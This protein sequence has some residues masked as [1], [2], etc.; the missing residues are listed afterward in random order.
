MSDVIGRWTV[1]STLKRKSYVVEK[2]GKDIKTGKMVRLKFMEIS[3]VLHEENLKEMGTELNSIKN[4]RHKHITKLYAYNLNSNYQLS[5]QSD[6]SKEILLVS[7]NICG[8]ELFDIFH[9]PSFT[10]IVART[11]FH[12]I[13]CGLEACHMSNVIHKDLRAENVSIDA[14]YNI[15]ITNIGLLNVPLNNTTDSDNYYHAPELLLN[16]SYSKKCDIFSAG[17]ILFILIN[18][19]PPFEKA[20]KK[21]KWY[22]PIIKGKI[23][24]FWKAHRKSPIENMSSLKDLMIKIFT[25]DPNKRIDINGI[26]SHLWYQCETLQKHELISEIYESHFKAVQKRINSS[27]KMIDLY[28]KP[29]IGQNVNFSEWILKPFPFQYI[30]GMFGE[31]YTYANLN[32]HWWKIYK[33]FEEQIASN[34]EATCKYDCNKQVLI[35]KV[36]SGIFGK[37]WIKFEIAIFESNIWKDEYKILDNVDEIVKRNEHQILVVKITRIEGDAFFYRR[38]VHGSLSSSSRCGW[39]IKGLPK[40]A[41]TIEVK[42]IHVMKEKYKYNLKCL[43]IGYIKQ[44]IG[45]NQCFEMF[46]IDMCFGYYFIRSYRFFA[47]D[48]LCLQSNN[49]D[50]YDKELE[51]SFAN[52]NDT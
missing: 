49:M 18:G 10:E 17:V 20:S 25:F 41:Q 14:K 15:K 24:K 52:E 26:K 4:I 44:N 23:D 16:Q 27:R 19:Y 48:L 6:N 47:T 11:F 42:K 32:E 50:E 29:F 46:I 36:P 12:Q 2:Q 39:C 28:C 13:I 5:Q 31:M 3:T 51:N 21:D 30:E 34:K 7:E 35:C 45:S 43:I 9:Y 38:F 1:G 33:Q 8:G 37:D 22:K 40:W